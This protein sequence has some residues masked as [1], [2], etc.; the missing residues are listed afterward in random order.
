MTG[1]QLTI[2]GPAGLIDDRLAQLEL[3][4]ANV[5][6]Q[7]SVR[8]QECLACSGNAESNDFCVRMRSNDQ[9]V[10]QFVLLTVVHKVYTRVNIVIAHAAIIRNVGLPSIQV[11]RK[12]GFAAFDE[13]GLVDR[14]AKI[15]TA[16]R[17]VKNKSK[18]R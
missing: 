17:V 16:S 10:F 5:Q 6:D 4:A 15:I 3:L 12:T 2:A 14:G 18:P 11:S 13:F 8:I 1:N 7:I 9:I